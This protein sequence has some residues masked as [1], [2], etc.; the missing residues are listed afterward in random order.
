MLCK[1]CC[2]KDDVQRMSCKNVVHGCCANDVVEG[3]TI[4]IMSLT[5]TG[6]APPSLARNPRPPPAA[7]AGI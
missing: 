6:P 3:R 1:G 5:S 4:T 2:A 7:V